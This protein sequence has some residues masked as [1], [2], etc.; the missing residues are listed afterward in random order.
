MLAMSLLTLPWQDERIALMAVKI[1]ET[2]LQSE[3]DISG[4]IMVLYSSSYN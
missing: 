4:W 2:G 3:L 1:G